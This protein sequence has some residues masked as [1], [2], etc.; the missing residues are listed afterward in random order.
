M[1]R[2]VLL[3]AVVSILILVK[4]IWFTGSE[5]PVSQPASVEHRAAEPERLRPV[6]VPASKLLEARAQLYGDMSL[7]ACCAGLDAGL[8]ARLHELVEGQ[9]FADARDILELA[10]YREQNGSNPSYWAALAQVRYEMG[11]PIGAADA[12]KQLR[13]IAGKDAR[14]ELAAL[15]LAREIGELEGM[16][17]GRVI[18]VLLE[19]GR[20]DGLLVLAAFH[21]GQ[22]RLFEGENSAWFGR[23]PRDERVYVAAKRLVLAAQRIIQHHTLTRDRS[24]P[25]IGRARIVF[26]TPEGPRVAI[27]PI[28]DLEKGVAIASPVYAAAT[29]LMDELRVLA[30]NPTTQRQSDRGGV[31]PASAGPGR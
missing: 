22:A 19:F 12:A 3:A 24:L 29:T 21:D 28:R 2:W 8:R 16:D 14:F 4:L 6:P 30:G 26:L 11:D 25:P 15:T 18:G 27:Y 10:T 1:V 9:K 20:E 13:A 7:G 5:G 17:P 23:A 31:G